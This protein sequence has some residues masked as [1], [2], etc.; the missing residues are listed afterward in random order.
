VYFILELRMKI[1][2]QI[3]GFCKSASGI[4]SFSIVIVG[5]GSSLLVRHDAKNIMN[6]VKSNKSV[7]ISGVDSIFKLRI[8]PVNTKI[9]TVIT[10]QN[11]LSDRLKR[12]SINGNIFQNNYS[13]LLWDKFGNEWMKY[14]DGMQVTIIQE[15]YEPTKSFDQKPVFKMHIEQDTTKKKKR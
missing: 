15:A 11:T 6:F 9:G 10:N 7:S 3:A 13:R 2:D 14:M 5:L 12:D 1:F 4:V 8:E